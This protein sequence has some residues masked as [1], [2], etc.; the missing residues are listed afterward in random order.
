MAALQSFTTL[1]ACLPCSCQTDYSIRGLLFGKGSPFSC[2]SLPGEHKWKRGGGVSK[3]VCPQ[4]LDFNGS[5]PLSSI[6]VNVRIMS[7]L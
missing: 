4:T 2:Q 3:S 7:V 6:T 5:A 1:I